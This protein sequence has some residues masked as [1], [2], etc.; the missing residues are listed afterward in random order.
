MLPHLRLYRKPLESHDV[1]RTITWTVNML[2]SKNIHLTY[3]GENVEIRVVKGWPQRGIFLPILWCI[4]VDG[5][6]LKQNA[7]GYTAQAYVDDRAI[8]IQG[9]YFSTVADLMP[10]NLKVLDG[11]CKTKGLS[12]H[13]EKTEVVLFTRERKIEGVVTLEYQCVQLNLSKVLSLMTN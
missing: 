10:G 12:I 2:K 13:S 5:L 6:L 1:R 3:W 4:V 7:M 9:K 11:L 8:V